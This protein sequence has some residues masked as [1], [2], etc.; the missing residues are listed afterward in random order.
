M[1]TTISLCLYLFLGVQ[2]CAL[3][4]LQWAFCPVAWSKCLM[5]ELGFID[6]LL[7]AVVGMSPK[8]CGTTVSEGPV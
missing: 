1:Q 3:L 6:A 7:R 8:P 5:C 4:A 2:V